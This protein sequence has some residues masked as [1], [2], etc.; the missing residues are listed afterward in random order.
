MTWNS[1]GVKDATKIKGTG[2]RGRL[3]KGDVLTHFKK[4]SSPSG[5][6]QKM[7]QADADARLAERSKLG[8]SSTSK[9]T[10]AQVGILSPLLYPYWHYFLVLILI[11]TFSCRI[12]RRSTLRPFVYLSLR[13]YRVWPIALQLPWLVSPFL[14]C[15]LTKKNIIKCRAYRWVIDLLYSFIIRLSSGRLFASLFGHKNNPA[16]RDCEYLETIKRQI[17]WRFCVTSH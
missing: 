2:L 1:R 3:T 6:A 14:C 9:S 8:S 11:F 12:Y 4:A 15:S 7:I 5:T 17:L 10:E 16:N 13:D